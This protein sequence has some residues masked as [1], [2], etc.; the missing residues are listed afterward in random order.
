M[1]QPRHRRR[2]QTLPGLTGLWQASGKN[3][4]TFE[5]MMELDLCY[6]ENKSLFLDM[7]I[8]ACTPLAILVQWCNVTAGRRRAARGAL[9]EN[10]RLRPPQNGHRVSGMEI[11]AQEKNRIPLLTETVEVRGNLGGCLTSRS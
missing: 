9:V 11:N 6:V 8:I 10:A 7:R 4:T 2:C 3:R 1:F 5:R